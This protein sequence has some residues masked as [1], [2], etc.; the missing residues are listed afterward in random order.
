MIIHLDNILTTEALMVINQ[1]LEVAQ[2][3]DGKKTAGWHAVTVKN[4]QQLS[5]QSSQAE[6]LKKMIYKALEN[7]SV[8]QMATLPRKIH[9][10]LLSRYEQGMG[11]GSHVDNALMGTSSIFRSDISFT[12]FLNSPSEYEGG[13]LV[14]EEINGERSFKLEAGSLILYPSYTLHRVETVASGIRKVAVGWIQS[15]VRDAQKREILFELDTVR[16]SIFNKEGKTTEFDLLS[17]CHANLLR[18]FAEN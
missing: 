17:K 14:L 5:S 10:L 3:I 13:E 4:N 16:R 6:T 2:F 11:Y 1:Q 12:I 7:N 15:L 18:Q 9:S 8:F